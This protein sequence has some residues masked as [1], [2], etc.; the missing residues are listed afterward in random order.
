MKKGSASAAPR[1]GCPRRWRE[2]RKL[3]QAGLSVRRLLAVK[4][5][6]GEQRGE[7]APSESCKTFHCGRD[8][9]GMK[10]SRKPPDFPAA[11]GFAFLSLKRKNFPGGFA[12]IS[13][14]SKLRQCSPDP[15]LRRIF[16]FEGFEKP[17]RG[18]FPSRGRMMSLLHLRWRPEHQWETRNIP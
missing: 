13:A 9:G 14:R 16:S 15:F 3:L 5:K 1:E 10:Q 18:K 7:C 17:L 8:D 6:T 4:T 12:T 2:N 11:S